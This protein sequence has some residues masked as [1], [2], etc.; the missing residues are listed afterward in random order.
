LGVKGG[1]TKLLTG[2]KDLGTCGQFYDGTSHDRR[3]S[4]SGVGKWR[5][6]KEQVAWWVV[7]KG[8]RS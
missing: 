2:K 8:N 6:K 4:F 3:G 7:K 1:R 5:T